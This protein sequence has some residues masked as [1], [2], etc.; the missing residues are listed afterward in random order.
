VGTE[1]VFVLGNPLYYDVVCLRTKYL[2]SN[3][4]VQKFLFELA[5]SK[6][7]FFEIVHAGMLQ[8]CLVGT[9]NASISSC[10]STLNKIMLM[11]I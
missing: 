4:C 8:F 9:G 6:D 3:L 10:Q 7:F 2:M 1:S 11:T 5:K